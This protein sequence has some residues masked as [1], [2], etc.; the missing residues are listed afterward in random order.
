VCP[1]FDELAGSDINNWIHF[2]QDIIDHWDVTTIVPGHGKPCGKEGLKKM[3]DL[4]TELRDKVAKAVQEGLTLEQTLKQIDLPS[5]KNLRGLDLL[6]YDIEA[7]YK[8]LK[9]R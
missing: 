9:E 1:F 2:I 4:I 7:V 5:F 8:S 6:K 3:L